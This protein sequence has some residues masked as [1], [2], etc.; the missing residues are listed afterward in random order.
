MTTPATDTG[1]TAPVLDTSTASSATAT[2]RTVPVGAFFF[3][4]VW[5]FSYFAV[6][7][8]IAGLP[9]AL[10]GNDN[11]WTSVVD[12]GVTGDGSDETA[13]IQAAIDGSQ[14]PGT[15]TKILVPAG[16]T[17]SISAQ[18]LNNC[19]TSGYF[20][21]NMVCLFLDSNVTFRV[22]GTLKVLPMS[23]AEMTFPSSLA[24]FENR[25][26]F[27]AL[28]GYNP[29]S[30][31][32]QPAGY[33]GTYQGVQVSSQAHTNGVDS[34]VIQL[35]NTPDLSS[36]EVRLLQAM[37]EGLFTP[38]MPRIWLRGT[39]NYG[40]HTITAVDNTAKTVTI[41]DTVNI[42]A[43]ADVDWFIENDIY[44]ERIRLEGVGTIDLTGAFTDTNPIY[45]IA[46]FRFMR[47]KDLQ[48]E[49][50]K[51]KGG[52]YHSGLIQFCQDVLVTNVRMV[53]L[54]Y[55][56]GY[57]GAP[58]SGYGYSLVLDTCRYVNVNSCTITDSL[59]QCQINIRC[60]KNTKIVNCVC[61]DAPYVDYS[62]GGLTVKNDTGGWDFMESLVH[63]R[64]DG[65]YRVPGQEAWRLGID[66]VSNGPTD[67]DLLVQGTTSHRNGYGIILLVAT[68]Y[69]EDGRGC[70]I[71]DNYITANAW[72]GIG[73]GQP[74]GLIVTGNVIENNGY[75]YTVT[76]GYGEK[77]PATTK[78]PPYD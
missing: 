31:I 30:P 60:C 47:V 10:A 15:K 51:I 77:Y 54:N 59:V 29:A 76:G 67:W 52:S 53:E 50:I 74:D 63:W 75:G 16:L 78:A 69:G 65:G 23:A 33:T 7:A 4:T 27:W 58:T 32:D 1:I 35:T 49:G 3:N 73:V 39:S 8:P 17:V 20:Q 40:Y 36:V 14:V 46:G 56:W 62:I 5:D 64:T 43:A 18:H 22:D 21:K 71:T 45:W 44:D 34:S 25:N 38:Y 61:R 9:E 28:L 24:V 12:Y 66:G 2:E 42:A 57:Q 19:I 6:D 13:K 72:A 26:S 11:E 41:S 55:T 68:Y 70:I 37:P 48:I